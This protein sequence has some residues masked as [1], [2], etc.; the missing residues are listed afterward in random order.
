M[1]RKGYFITP[2]AAIRQLDEKGMYQVLENELYIDEDG[3]PYFC[4]HLF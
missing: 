1:G 3:V 4:W 2:K